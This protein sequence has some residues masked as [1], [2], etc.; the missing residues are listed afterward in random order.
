MI[1]IEFL[2]VFIIPQA[3][4]TFVY[5]YT[6]SGI[7][8]RIAMR[9]RQDLFKSVIMQDMAF[10]DRNRTGE[11]L[12]RLTGDIQDFKSA[13]K[14]CFAQGLRSVAQIIGCVI[15]ITMISPQ[16]TGV[17]VMCVPTVIL[18]GAFLGSSLRKM[19]REA[20]NQTAKSTAVSEEAI[21]N[22]RTVKIPVSTSSV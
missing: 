14:M 9:L 16:L 15:S 18:V 21:S 11:I 5:I 12:N 20:Q 10:F 17:M 7:G 13:F 19:S 8:E 22:I 6:L 2:P 3:L 4:F 1:F